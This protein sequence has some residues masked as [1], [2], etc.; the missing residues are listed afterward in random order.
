M[1]ACEFRY[2]LLYACSSFS[3]YLLQDAILEKKQDIMKIT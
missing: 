2:Y 3:Y 1:G